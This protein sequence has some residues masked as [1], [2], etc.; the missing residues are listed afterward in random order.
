MTLEQTKQRAEGAED[1]SLSNTDSRMY[2]V[3]KYETFINTQRFIPGSHSL[4][5]LTAVPLGRLSSRSCPGW[6]PPSAAPVAAEQA[7][8]A[9]RQLLKLMAE[10]PSATIEAM[11]EKLDISRM[12]VAARI[13][14]LKEKRIL[15]RAGSDR[16]GYW[17]IED[18]KI[19]SNHSD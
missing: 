15:R 8:D 13:K 2:A 18:V 3:Q 6:Q 5:F 11:S 12:T 1:V 14:S 4:S 16:A 17:M 10:N 19:D 7:T 9:E